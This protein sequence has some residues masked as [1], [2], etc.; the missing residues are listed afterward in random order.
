A[1]S[2]EALAQLF[3]PGAP[4]KARLQLW[5]PQ[6]GEGDPAVIADRFKSPELLLLSEWLANL[7]QLDPTTVSRTL[8]E[9]YGS[10]LGRSLAAAHATPLVVAEG[11]RWA[12]RWPRLERAQAV[13]TYPQCAW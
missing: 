6:A 10:L 13:M 12:L 4:G 8:L 5:L 2:A 7:P 9:S 11:G 1:G 3:A